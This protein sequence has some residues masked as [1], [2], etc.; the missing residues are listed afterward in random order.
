MSLPISP[1][2]ASRAYVALLTEDDVLRTLVKRVLEYS[3]FTVLEAENGEPVFGVSRLEDAGIESVATGPVKGLRLSEELYRLQ[4]ALEQS[5]CIFAAIP[6]ILVGVDGNGTIVR[7]N[8]A[9]EEAFGICSSEALGR[10][11]RDSGIRWEDP[12]VV[13]RITQSARGSKP[14]RID[15]LSFRNVDGGER[16]LGLT[17][18]PLNGAKCPPNGFVVLAADITERKQLQWQLQQ[19]QKLEAVGELAGGVAHEFNNLLQVISGYTDFAMESLSPDEQPYQDLQQAQK[20]T[21]RA[22]MLTRELLE[23]SRKQ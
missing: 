8:Q 10:P 9:A 7:W 23:F 12:K 14:V 1:R 6:S 2:T 19:A 4:R 3:G 15:E 21:E 17:V 5:E 18:C 13:E 16:F 20:A 22:T 11:F